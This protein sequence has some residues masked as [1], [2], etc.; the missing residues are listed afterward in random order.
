MIGR[1]IH[2]V[3]EFVKQIQQHLENYAWVD[4]RRDEQRIG[5][6]RRHLDRGF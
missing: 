2:D 6:S 5:L 3:I 4:T 1:A